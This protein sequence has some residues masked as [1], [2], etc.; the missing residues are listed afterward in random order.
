[1]VPP[2]RPPRPTRARDAL[3]R[4]LPPGVAGVAPVD[5]RPRP[6]AEAL[7]L[8][9]RLLAAGRPFQAHEV[10]EA[11][12]KA[13]PARDREERAL[14]RGLAQLAVGLTHQARGNRAGA[15]AVLRRSAA[16]LAGAGDV[17]ERHEV[18]AAGLAAW[19]RRR[20][21]AVAGSMELSDTAPPPLGRPG[22]AG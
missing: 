17:A 9:G 1:M 18:D 22:R 21:E 15:V 2:G 20:A 19:A 7:E 11:V 10:L 14:W 5:E 12:W 6:P 16:T 4:P 3:G 8:A 13:T